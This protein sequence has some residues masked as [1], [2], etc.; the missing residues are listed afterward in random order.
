MSRAISLRVEVDPDSSSGGDERRRKNRATEPILSF[1]CGA[2]QQPVAPAVPRVLHIKA[3]KTGH[4]K[5]TVL[6]TWAGISAASARP[7]Y[8]NVYYIKK[9]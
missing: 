9:I 1:P 8:N 6:N 3:V 4:S 7:L 2:E 5:H